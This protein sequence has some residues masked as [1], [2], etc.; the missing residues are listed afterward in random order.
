MIM[1][2]LKPFEYYKE[3]CKVLYKTD[4]IDECCQRHQMC[5][6]VHFAVYGL[7]NPNNFSI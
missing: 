3:L 4:P 2:I 6:A 5:N 1:Q 7:Q